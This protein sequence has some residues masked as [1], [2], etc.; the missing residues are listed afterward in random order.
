[1]AGT[2]ILDQDLGQPHDGSDRRPEFLA[3]ESSDRALDA[4]G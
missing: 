3:H 4:L 2:G 1:M